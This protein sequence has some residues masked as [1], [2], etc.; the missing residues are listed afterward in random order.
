MIVFAQPFAFAL[1]LALPVILWTRFGSAFR[2]RTKFGAGRGLATL[3]ASAA[4]RLSFLPPLLFILGFTAWVVALARPVLP[5]E[6]SISSTDV[7][8]IVLVIDTSSSMRALDMSE[9]GKRRDRLDASKEVV[10]DFIKQRERDRIGLVAFAGLPFTLSPVIDDHD[11]L[12]KRLDEVRIGMVRDGT[13]IGMAVASAVNRLKDSDSKTKL[14]VLLTDG[15]NTAGTISPT[16]AANLAKTSNVKIYAI[17]VGSNGLVDVPHPF[18][19]TVQQRMRLDEET[20]KKMADITGGVYFNAKNFEELQTVYENVNALERTEIELE[21][22]TENEEWFWPF[23]AAGLGLLVL[24]RALT[25]F[26]LGR[27]RL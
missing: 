7:I 9:N 15:E 8:D 24:D 17:G 2:P 1:L 23:A 12:Q 3:P 4:Q 22:Y 16:E 27:V 20:L 10:S 13:G 25:A 5:L 6:E 19:G 26:G 14:V 18:F 11:W 21:T